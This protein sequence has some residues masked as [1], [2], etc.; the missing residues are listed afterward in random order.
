MEG[1]DK[2]KLSDEEMDLL[3]DTVQKL[4]NEENWEELKNLLLSHI[5]QCP[6]NNYWALTEL[7]AVYG[8]LDMV[9]DSLSTAE[10][11][12]QLKGKEDDVWMNYH[13]AHALW[14]NEKY[15]EAVAQCNIILRK[16]IETI[17]YNEHGEGLKF[18]R[19]IANDTLY[20]KGRVMMDQGKYTE[21]KKMISKHLSQRRRGIYSDYPR[22]LVE[23]KLKELNKLMK[24]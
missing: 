22:R 19:G 9:E 8:Q 10:K 15:D 7:S 21:A 14:K 12:M 20:M 2:N 23:K 24:V 6:D 4:K 16:R 11:A 3:N 1:I 13:Y 18:A 5:D 17:A